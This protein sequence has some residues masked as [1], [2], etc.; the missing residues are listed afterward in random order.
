MILK[1]LGSIMITAASCCTGNLFAERLIRRCKNLQ[2]FI[3]ALVNLENEIL[4]KAAPLPEALYCCAKITNESI[5]PFLEQTASDI[6]GKTGKL[7]SEIWSDNIHAFKERLCLDESDAD[8]IKS[9]GATIGALDID[10][11]A[12]SIKLCRK[13]IGYA[14]Q[15]SLDD[16]EKYVKVYKSAGMLVGI[17]ISI[18]FI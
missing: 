12:N 18:L 7:I 4:F 5:S 9:L 16:K 6:A 2:D 1:I 8:I 17:F 11:Q 15:R 14:L 10:I 3:T 13:N